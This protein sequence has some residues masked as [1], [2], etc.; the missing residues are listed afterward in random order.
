MSHHRRASLKDLHV[1]IALLV[2]ASSCSSMNARRAAAESAEI[3]VTMAAPLATVRSRVL[4]A[5]TVNKLTVTSQQDQ[6]IEAKLP[7]E[8]GFLGDYDITARAVLIPTG[9]ETRV[10]LYGEE[11]RTSEVALSSGGSTTSHGN[12]RVS[13]YSSGRAAKVWHQLEAVAAALRS[14]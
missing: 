8:D 1:A 4:E 9:S 3:T 7:R 13:Q 5:F 14:P 6:L 10:T 12:Q 11:Q 2:L